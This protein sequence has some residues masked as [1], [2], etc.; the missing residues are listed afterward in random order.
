MRKVAS[1]LARKKRIVHVVKNLQVVLHRQRCWPWSASVLVAWP[2]KAR[3]G[4]MPCRCPLS[5]P[6]SRHTR[7]TQQAAVLPVAL[8]LV[9]RIRLR[10]IA[11]CCP[12][13]RVT[14]AAKT[15]NEPGSFLEHDRPCGGGGSR[16]DPARISYEATGRTSGARST[17]AKKT[18][19]L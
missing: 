15:A 10:Q 18:G 8:F 16:F 7:Q 9:C 17:T 4:E 12:P 5:L 19:V 1:A 3:T 2:S 6:S 11:Q 14:P 13:S